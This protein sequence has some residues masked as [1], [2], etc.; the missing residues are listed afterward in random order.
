MTL[1]F[2]A[3]TSI[4]SIL[5]FNKREILYK[6]QFNAYQ[7]LRRKQYLR[8]LLHGFLHANWTHLLINMIVLYSFGRSLELYFQH[9]FGSYS[10]LYFSILYLAALLI[11]PVYALIKHRDNY[12]YN[13]VGAS[14]AVSA[15]VF[16]AIFFDPW[17]KIYFFGILPMPGILFAVLY[18]IY[19]WQMSKRA[20]DN[21]AHDT[22]F[23]GAIFG[24][25]YPIILNPGLFSYFIDQLLGR[26]A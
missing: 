19:S 18:L 13:A 25:I 16:A 2:I 4:F 21:V 6:Y 9:I 22:H 1:F 14:G 15:V 7:I 11:S 10:A 20:G 17:N 5:A 26:M 12:L 3:I 8:L 23:T 24:L